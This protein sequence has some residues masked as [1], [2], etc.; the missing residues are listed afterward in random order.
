MPRREA[1]QRGV[2]KQLFDSLSKF[3]VQDDLLADVYVVERE[4][5]GWASEAIGCRSHDDCVSG[6]CRYSFVGARLNW[7]LGTNVL[8][9][10]NKLL[11]AAGG[12]TGLSST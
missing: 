4:G 3:R 8:T 9:A 11:A 6:M 7:S 5:V 2:I 12:I 10:L 1:V